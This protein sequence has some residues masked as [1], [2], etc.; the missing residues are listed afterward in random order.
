MVLNEREPALTQVGLLLPQ[1][2]VPQEVWS[3]QEMVPLGELPGEE[4]PVLT[5]LGG[6]GGGDGLGGGG[7]G[8]GLGGGG[9]E[10]TGAT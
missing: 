3:M 10:L 8:D 4:V 9:G 7:G 1:Q 2:A 6:G 5:G